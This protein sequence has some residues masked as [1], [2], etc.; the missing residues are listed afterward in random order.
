[1][2]AFLRLRLPSKYLFIRHCLHG[3][4]NQCNKLQC[5]RKRPLFCC[6]KTRV[7]LVLER[8]D[9]DHLGRRLGSSLRSKWREATLGTMRR[10]RRKCRMND[11][12]HTVVGMSFTEQEKNPIFYSRHETRL[13]VGYKQVRRNVFV[14]ESFQD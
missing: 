3:K 4:P 10:R 2:R 14:S 13:G 8:K 6:S 5:S 11:L 7:I 9:Y 1:M 12:C